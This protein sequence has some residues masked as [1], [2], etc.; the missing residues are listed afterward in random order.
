LGWKVLAALVA[1]A[2]VVGLSTLVTKAQTPPAAAA[3]GYICDGKSTCRDAKTRLPLRVLP[4]AQRNMYAQ[5]NDTAAPTES[6][7]TPFVPLYVFERNNVSY[8]DPVRPQGWF[9]VGKTSDKADGYMKAADVLEWKSAIVVSYAHRGIEGNQR[10]PVIMFKDKRPL[11]D[12]MQD[13][14]F[15]ERATE[16]YKRLE[17]SDVPDEIITR[18]PDTFVD[19]KKKFY[20]LPVLNH[21]DLFETMGIEDARILQIA[22]AVP[23]RATMKAEDICT[24]EM[25]DKFA[26]C[27]AKKGTVTDDELKIDVIYVI[28]FTG[29]MQEH[30]N[31][32]L[33]AMRTSATTFQGA[34]KSKSEDRVRFGLVGYRDHLESVGTGENNEYVFKNFTPELVSRSRLVE[35]LQQNGK[36]QGGGDIEEEVFPGVLEAINSKWSDNS[37][38]LIFLIGDASSHDPSHR[39]S[40]TQKDA[41]TVRL[42]ANEQNVYL[43]SIYIKN[44]RQASDWAKGQEQ[45]RI[46]AENPGGTPS[47]RA[48]EENPEEIKNALLEVTQEMVERVRKLHADRVR[49]AETASAPSSGPV[50]PKSGGEA[51]KSAFNA[52]LVEF[53][54]RATEPPPDITA[55]VLDKDLTNLNRRAFDVHVLLTRADLDQLTK[56]I[57]SLIEAYEVSKLTGDKFFKSLQSVVTTAALDVEI[58]LAETLANS[59]LF[60]SWIAAMPYKSEV[61][62]LKFS[63]FEEM[64][65]DKRQQLQQKLRGLVTLY[66]QILERQ[67]SWV[68]LNDAMKHEDY[69][70]PMPIDNLP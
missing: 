15:N 56:S 39:F 57:Q 34:A 9:K 20:L 35:L 45:F 36:A 53:I 2:G 4:R 11:E 58:S 60:P 14:K 62:T 32:T 19:I 42:F 7:I 46:L 21:I 10:K 27:A 43:A 3:D 41:R 64:T 66:R 31:A 49:A 67:E 33:E 13:A 26:E 55:W 5:T 63:D 23:G 8:A 48:V 22:A 29:S 69:V 50:L 47:F 54:G 30:I 40:T 52:G 16:Y 44:P 59:P 51:L 18:E 37:V 25:K 1:M 12:L 68:K 24:T 28:D 17:R 6:N 61:T 70:Y 38:R 65:A